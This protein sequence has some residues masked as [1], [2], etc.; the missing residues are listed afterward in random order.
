MLACLNRNAV[1][2]V[3]LFFSILFFII[4]ANSQEN[5]LSY[6][7]DGVD[8]F[9]SNDFKEAVRFFYIAKGSTA[10]LSTQSRIAFEVDYLKK[11]DF[12]RINVECKELGRML[13]AIIKHRG[14]VSSSP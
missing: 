8:A 6:F 4:P 2:A 5:D 13:G 14:K 9:D 1:T 3:I 11:K 12:D 10:E 7:A